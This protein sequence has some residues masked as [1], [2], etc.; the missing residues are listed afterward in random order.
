MEGF[1]NFSIYLEAVAIVPQLRML[2]TTKSADA[3][4]VVYLSTLG[5]YRFIYL[6][7]YVVAY[8]LHQSFNTF[9]FLAALVQCTI[10]FSFL[11]S[12]VAIL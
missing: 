5:L 2:Q 6:I 10:Y 7:G 4:I 1:W 8:Y 12:A 11:V 9:S 3:G